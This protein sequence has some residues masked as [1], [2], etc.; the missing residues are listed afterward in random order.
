MTAR[1]SDDDSET[2]SAGVLTGIR[3]RILP[4]VNI[5]WGEIPQKLGMRAY[6]R[7]FKANTRFLRKDKRTTR[8]G[9]LNRLEQE[10]QWAPFLDLELGFKSGVTA[11]MRLDRSTR[12]TEDLT[13]L[14]RISDR[15][16]SKIMLSAKKSMTIT[17]EVTVPLKKTKERI[18]T[19]LDL[20][21][22]FNYSAYQDVTRQM[23]Y[24][25]QVTADVKQYEAGLGGSYQ[26][27]RS[28]TGNMILNY[29]E[30]ADNKNRTRTTRY[31]TVSLSASFSF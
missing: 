15:T 14:K 29:G 31:A 19:K 6:F 25:P 17:R 23:G 1:Y 13:A 12:H 7:S 4:E 24:N 8:E 10:S 2:R 28:V 22:S 30:N 3:D 11:T 27:T 5:R 18:T 9:E 21:L 16:D 20:T 26:F